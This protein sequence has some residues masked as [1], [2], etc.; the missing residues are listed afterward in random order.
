MSDQHDPN[1]GTPQEPA[2]PQTEP[3]PE[4]DETEGD[5]DPNMDPEESVPTN[6]EF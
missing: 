6:K 4:P 1:E 3:D 2:V 5:E